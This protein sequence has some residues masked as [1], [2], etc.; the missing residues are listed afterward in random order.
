MDRSQ[1]GWSVRMTLRVGV[2]GAGTMGTGI[3]YAFAAKGCT[4]QGVAHPLAE[5][6]VAVEL[7]RVAAM[8]AAELADS[9]ADA[10][11]LPQRA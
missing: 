9:G 11:D 4:H 2:I 1:A 5:A 10:A 3:T 6:Y 7:S 8:R